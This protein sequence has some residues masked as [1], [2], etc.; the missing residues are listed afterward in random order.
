MAVTV[1]HLAAYPGCRK[2]ERGCTS[3]EIALCIGGDTPTRTVHTASFGEITTAVA[4]FG[5][6]VLAA[7]PDASFIIM[8]DVAKGQRKPRGFYVADNAKQFGRKRSCAATSTMTP[9]T[10]SLSRRQV[11]QRP[12]PRK[13][14]ARTA[15]QKPCRSRLPGSRARAAPI[16]GPAQR[17]LP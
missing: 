9:S 14:G 17:P 1:I 3:T 12:E 4:S 8:V 11:R 6:D 5:K 7:N 16:T 2:L 10:A 13:A 15:D